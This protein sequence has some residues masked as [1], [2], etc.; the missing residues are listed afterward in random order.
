L[1]Y[2]RKLTIYVD[3]FTVSF[4][5]CDMQTQAAKKNGSWKKTRLKNL[6]RHK[7]GR[8]YAR[9]YVGG[10][11]VWQPLGTS[12][13]SVAE[14]KLAKFL[15]QYRSVRRRGATI[16][17]AKMT[18]GDAAQ[19]H[20]ENLNRNVKIKQRTRDYWNETLIALYK[21]WPELRGTQLRN[22]R[23]ADFEKWAGDYA[24][25]ASATRYNNTVHLVR[26]VLNVG[27]AAGVLAHNV[28]NALHRISVK[29]KEPALPSLAQFNSLL[30][31][32]RE[33]HGRFSKACADL[34]AGL[35]FTGCRLGEARS[36]TWGDID[37]D[38][39]RIVIRGNPETGTKN[40]E[41][42]RF[43]LLPDARALFERMR[44][45]FPDDGS[46]DR[47][48]CVGECQKAID[49]AAK[50]VGMKRITHHSL[51][52]FFAMRCIESGVDIPT[53]SRWL[54]HKDGGVLA[55]KTYGHLRDEHDQAQARLVSFAAS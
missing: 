33:G 47:V 53:V 9:A 42:R 41:I 27:V 10:K 20:L 3:F 44:A 16:A 30:H 29:P 48:F 52:H 32:M 11:E 38:L 37:F 5:V 23:Q 18:F 55:M 13:F 49:R 31:E 46:Q 25:T 43:R 50:K 19:I 22:I 54:G 51:R 34:A 1:S 35:A 14:V 40:R 26:H 8:Y 45:D 24:R 7:S 4:T 21:R 2:G 12:H 28:A 6:L 36:L 39:G 15:E 17:S